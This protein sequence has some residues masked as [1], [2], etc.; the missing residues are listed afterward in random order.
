[1]KGK[2][3]S[4][5]SE[6]EEMLEGARKKEELAKIELM[7]EAEMQKELEMIPEPVRKNSSF[8][9]ELQAEYFGKRESQND[10]RQSQ[11]ETRESGSR[12]PENEELYYFIE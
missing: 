11:K 5:K 10:K 9:A 7:I 1:M 8:E 3:Q 6:I 12:R 4:Y 2:V